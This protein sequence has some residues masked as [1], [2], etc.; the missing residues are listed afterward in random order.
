M[1]VVPLQTPSDAQTEYAMLRASFQRFLSRLAGPTLVQVLSCTNAGGL[2]AVGTVN[3]QALVNQVSGNG[4]A[5]PHGPVYS[6][7]YLRIQGGAN[8]IIMDP[9]ADDIGMAC[10][11]SRDISAVKSSKAQ[12]NPGSARMWDWADGLYIGGYLNGV[13]NQYM[14]YNSTGIAVVSPTQI[15]L[16]APT[17]ILDASTQVT[18]TT[19][20]AAFSDEVTIDD[21]AVIG[22][23][24]YL[25]HTHTSEAPGTPTSPPIV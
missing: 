22:M 17:I 19:P 5:Q 20:T 25:E 23:S 8:A 14:Q 16:Q 1:N 18:V 9:Q 12:A 2:T 10:F 4:T 21:D 13:P 3:V 15:L 24:D 7:P 6:L 11:C